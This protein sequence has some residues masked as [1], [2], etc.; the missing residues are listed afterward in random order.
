MIEST[1]EQSCPRQYEDNVLHVVR[2]CT[3]FR[4][5]QRSIIPNPACAG[6]PREEPKI[7]SEWAKSSRWK[8]VLPPFAI[9]RVD[10]YNRR[11]LDLSIL[12]R[13]QRGSSE[14]DPNDWDGGIDASSSNRRDVKT[15]N[16]KIWGQV[17]PI[18]LVIVVV[19]VEFSRLI[20]KKRTS[21]G[22]TSRKDPI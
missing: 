10:R 4:S 2:V 21:R 20:E 1:R 15:R 16:G 13:I 22:Q 6:A 9:R 19:V 12:L 18:R 17:G 11:G 5:S 14:Y 8:I 3:H 7:P